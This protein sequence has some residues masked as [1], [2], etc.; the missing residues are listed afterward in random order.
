MENEKLLKK[1][2]FGSEQKNFFANP[3]KKKFFSGV[4]F[5]TFFAR[6]REKKFLGGIFRV[7]FARQRE[8]KI[9]V[10]FLGFTLDAKKNRPPFRFQEISRKFTDKT[11]NTLDPKK[12]PRGFF[13]KPW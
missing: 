3:L 9:L 1:N 8:K 11:K 13:K 10:N 2:F 5:W 12:K 6:Q 7:F 4:S